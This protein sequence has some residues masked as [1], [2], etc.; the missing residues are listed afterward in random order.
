V[1]WPKVQFY[2]LGIGFESLCST[3]ADAP[4][5]SIWLKPPMKIW[6]DSESKRESIRQKVERQLGRRLHD[7]SNNSIDLVFDLPESRDEL[8]GMLTQNKEA[9]FADC[10]VSH[11]REL[12]KFIPLINEMFKIKKSAARR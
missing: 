10:M 5:A 1:K 4:R 6:I 2:I 7:Y 3:D 12:A 9:Q 11:F 8:L